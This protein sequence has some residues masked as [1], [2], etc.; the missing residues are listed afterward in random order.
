[1]A[2]VER[3][4]RGR[5]EPKGLFEGTFRRDLRTGRRRGLVSSGLAWKG[6]EAAAYAPK[7]CLSRESY[8]KR[9][10]PPVL[11]QQHRRG[12]LNVCMATPR[13]GG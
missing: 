9:R 5:N 7:R 10:S 8:Y 12:M 2:R 13:P 4:E 1:M 6:Q 11:L 3:G